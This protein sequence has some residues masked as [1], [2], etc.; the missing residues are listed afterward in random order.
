MLDCWLFFS[1]ATLFDFGC[2]SQAQEMSW[3]KAICPISD[4]SLSPAHC[5]PFCLSS[6]CLLK[7]CMEISSFPLP[8]SQVCS[9]HT[10]SAAWSFSLPCLFRVFCC[11]WGGGQSVQGVCWFI[12][13]E[14]R[15]PLIC[16]SVGL[17]LPRRFGAG[18]WWHRT[19]HFLNV[20][21]CGEAMYGLG[22]Q[23]VG[24]LILLGGFF[25]PSVVLASQQNFWFTE[26]TLTASAL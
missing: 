6:L 1:F 18:I 25:L 17:H 16:S 26:L 5:W 13:G 10:P 9:E 22:V 2:C 11:C 23:G 19:P 7:V 8:P 14:Y 21:W 24:V 3:N 20:T 4:S 15:V 12:P